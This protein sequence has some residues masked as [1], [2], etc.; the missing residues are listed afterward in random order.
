[1]KTASEEIQKGQLE[2]RTQNWIK[3]LKHTAAQVISAT[4]A[5]E[6]KAEGAEEIGSQWIEVDKN[7]HL[8]AETNGN[9]EMELKVSVSRVIL[10]HKVIQPLEGMSA[11]GKAE[12]HD[13]QVQFV[14]YRQFCDDTTVERKRAITEANEKIDVL[15]ADIKKYISD[16]AMLTIATAGHDDDIAA[17]TG[18]IKAATKVRK[19]EHGRL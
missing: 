10:V 6:L 3:W 15:N 17:W 2:S 5:E 7:K 19:H 13:D 4:R 9:I 12:M 8:Q 14:A 18:D 16:A 11:K 1:M